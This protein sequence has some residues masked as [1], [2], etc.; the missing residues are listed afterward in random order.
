MLRAPVLTLLLT[1]GILASAQTAVQSSIPSAADLQKQAATAFAAKHFSDAVA[2]YTQALPLVEEDFDRANLEYNLACSQSLAGDR[3][4]ALN[5]LDHAIN[6]GYSNRKDTEADTDLIPLHADPHWQ[7]LLARMSTLTAQ[8]DRRWG[9]AAFASVPYSPNLSDAEKLAGLSELW[10]QARYSFAN[11]WH[12]PDLNWDQTYRDFI[13]QVL[14]TKSTAEFYQVLERFYAQLQ[15]GHSGVYPPEALSIS[16]MPLRT[17]MVDGH[18]LV[19]GTR[20]P[21]FDL[22][23][24]HP[25]DEIVSINGEPAIPWAR[26]NVEP[27]IS[28][29]TPQDR[30]NR[31]FGFQLFFAKEGTRFALDIASAGRATRKLIFTVPP[32]QKSDTPLFDLRLLPG[33]I[34]YVALHGFD[35]DTAAKEWDKNW[36]EI[37]KAKSLIL[38][39]RENGGGSDSVGAHILA[40]LLDR[41]APGELSRSTRWIATY[42]AWGDPQT[43]KRFPLEEL[44]PDPKHHFAGPVVLLT[45]PRTYSAGEDMTAIFKQAHRGQIIGEPTGGS[46]GQPLMFKLPGGGGARI[47]TKHDSFADGTEFVGIGIQPDVPAHLSPADIRSG[48]DSVLETAVRHLQ[49]SPPGLPSAAIVPLRP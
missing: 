49:S 4:A 15:D 22:Q 13:P 14:A 32:W 36:P 30:D 42:R 35:D 46:T 8:Q 11:F 45:S 16:P 1:S 33:N 7:V 24:L 37:S 9:D 26:R 21:G 31:T 25:G 17:R 44:D 6:D 39:L 5:T 34:A 29:S 10:A 18:L 40:T 43:P 47:C 3:A 27:F 48:R 23:G 20:R 19:L 28:A 2:L 41:P 12:V 38:D